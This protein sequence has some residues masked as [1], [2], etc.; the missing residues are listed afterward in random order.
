MKTLLFQTS[1]YNTLLHVDYPHKSENVSFVT[2]IFSKFCKLRVI[3]RK[4]FKEFVSCGNVFE[5]GRDEGGGLDG[6]EG[7]KGWESSR[8]RVGNETR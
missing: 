3:F 7:F 6:E 5:R 8:G 4:S 1:L 2:R